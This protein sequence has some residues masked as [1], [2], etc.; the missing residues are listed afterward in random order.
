MRVGL[1]VMGLLYLVRVWMQSILAVMED[2]NGR[3]WGGR[4]PWRIAGETLFQDV[5]QI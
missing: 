2:W 3:E 5:C 1:D 4:D